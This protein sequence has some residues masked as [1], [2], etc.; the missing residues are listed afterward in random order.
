LFIDD[1][2]EKSNSRRN[3]LDRDVNVRKPRDS[4]VL[5]SSVVLRKNVAREWNV[6]VSWSWKDNDRL[7][8]RGDEMRWRN[9]VL[10]T[11]SK[12][13]CV[14]GSF[15][16]CLQDNTLKNKYDTANLCL[17]CYGNISSDNS[18]NNVCIISTQSNVLP[19]SPLK[20]QK[21]LSVQ[22]MAIHETCFVT[23]E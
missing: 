5:L 10:R 18:I 9:N 13:H 15:H 16:W 17:K 14:H 21:L 12:K 3:K 22:T 20:K 4:S 23:S 11:N 2:R 1:R 8:N 7:K 6:N 19:P